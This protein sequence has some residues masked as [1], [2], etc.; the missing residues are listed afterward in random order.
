MMTCVNFWEMSTF[1]RTQKM[2]N[3]ACEGR[4][5][6]KLWWRLIAILT[7]KSFVIL[8]V[9][10]S[11]KAKYRFKT[12]GKHVPREKDEKEFGKMYPKLNIGSRPMAN[13]YHERKTKRTLER[14]R[15][16]MKLWK[17]WSKW[18]QCILVRLLRA[19]SGCA[20]C[21]LP[22]VSTSVWSRGKLKGPCLFRSRSASHL[23]D[24]WVNE[25]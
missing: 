15:K 16:C 1:V 12:D 4:S 20:W 18:N 25:I 10:P 23:A 2:V 6:G 3:Y 11:S 17:K 7:C 21:F 19:K 5:Q 22:C 24:F 13:K 8:H 14:C 9:Q